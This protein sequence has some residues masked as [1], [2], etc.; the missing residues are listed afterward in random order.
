MPYNFS[1]EAKKKPGEEE[2]GLGFSFSDFFSKM[3]GG[4]DTTSP[5]AAPRLI[6]EADDMAFMERASKAKSDWERW[7]EKLVL[8]PQ[9]QGPVQPIQSAMD[10]P[11]SDEYRTPFIN[12]GRGNRG[13]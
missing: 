6:S 5:T 1:G 4:G 10:A 12:F 11:I 13:V 7:N 2:K 9:W 3:A 8:S